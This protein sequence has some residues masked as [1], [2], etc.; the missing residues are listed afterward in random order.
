MN[1]AAVLT[2]PAGDPATRRKFQLT[3]FTD[4]HNKWWMIE[5]WPLG[6]HGYHAR[7][8]W[9]RVGSAAQSSE[10]V[11]TQAEVTRLIAEKQGKGYQEVDLHLPQAS[12]APVASAQAPSQPPLPAK[13]GQL[14][15]W[16]FREAGEHIAGFLACT[17]DAL[18]QDQIQRGRQLLDQAQR[19]Y[20]AWERRQPGGALAGLAETVQGFYNTIPTQL[21]HRID[22]CEVTLAF[23]R[24]FNEQEDRLNQLQ[25]ALATL[26]APAG[27]PGP[28]DPQRRRYDLLGAD[29][30]ALPDR[31]PVYGWVQDYVKRT[32]VHGTRMRVR[33]IFAVTLPTERQAFTAN[34][35]GRGRVETLFH[36]THNANV[37]HIL[38]SGLICPRT[39]S[40]GRM[41][42]HG[43]YFANLASKSGGYCT[44][45]ADV[46]HMMFLADVA[47]G[48]IY[49]PPNAEP[50]LTTPPAGFDSVMGKSGYTGGLINDEF[51][52]YRREQQTLRYLLTWEGR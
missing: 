30:A 11:C 12:S 48:R 35:Q 39:P 38:H 19:Q 36:G 4:N 25:A 49:T 27:T 52:V 34:P 28:S 18:S 21:P 37:R 3:D 17:V 20:A 29:I 44:A 1:R 24:D 6:A 41:F 5:L 23:C 32:A 10:K 42:G 15:D 51:I 13:V 50:H 31:D 8:T 22:P 9:G 45:G 16:I 43:I 14:I 47:L 46:P 40:H 26:T 2:T 7:T 33:D